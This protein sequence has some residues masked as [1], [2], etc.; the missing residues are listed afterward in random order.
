MYD[1]F[2]CTTDP[3]TD[4]APT[5]VDLVDLMT[6]DIT[7]PAPHILPDGSLMV[8]AEPAPTGYFVH[9][10]LSDISNA[11]TNWTFDGPLLPD[12]GPQALFDA[13]AQLQATQL[14][15]FTGIPTDVGRYDDVD[16]RIE[17][18]RSGESTPSLRP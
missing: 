6:P 15:G 16:G 10:P 14:N 17:F 12:P 18:V 2:D 4:A 5:Q 8:V 3:A 7:T 1:C 9:A 13:Q 11:P